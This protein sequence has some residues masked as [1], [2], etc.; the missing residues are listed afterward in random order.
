ML[1]CG[2]TF[3][4]GTVIVKRPQAEIDFSKTYRIKSRCEAL[5]SQNNYILSASGQ[6]F[7]LAPDSGMKFAIGDSLAFFGKIYPLKEHANTGAFSYERYLKQQGVNYKVFPTDTIYLTG[8]SYTPYSFFQD[9]RDKLLLKTDRLLKD[10]TNNAIIKALCTGYRNDMDSDIQ[11]LFIKTGT[12][13]LLSVSGLHTGAIYLLIVFLFR[14]A[15][16]SKPRI[17]LFII[18]LLWGYTCLTGL[19]PSVVRAATILTFI[20]IGNAFQKDYTPINSIAASAFLTL[21]LQPLVLYSVSFQMSYSAYCGIITLY[22]LLNRLPGKLPPVISSVWSLFC[23]SVTAQ[24]PTLPLT[25]YYFHTIGINNFLV[26]IIA[27]PLATLLL[28]AGTILLIL[29][30]AIGIHLVFI[31]NLINHLLLWILKTFNIISINLENLYPTVLHIL[32]L[33]LCLFS[34][35][36]FLIY[37]QQRM[38]RLSIISLATILLYCCLLNFTIRS[39]SEL[40]IFHLYN[41]SCILLNHKGY[42]TFLKNDADSSGLKTI[43]PYLFI[44]KVEPL[45]V[46][47]G[48]L[49]DQL[50]YT[51]NKLLFGPDTFYIADRNHKRYTSGTIIITDNLLPEHLFISEKTGCPV[52]III[53]GSNK[54]FYLKKWGEFCQKE[55]IPL[56]QTN[57]C[58]TISFPLK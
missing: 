19:S 35:S 54:R 36:L 31:I 53:D 14:I 28:Y 42:Y 15:G 4:C 17:H 29:P 7:Y 34:V 1:L 55:G 48:F 40:V 32:L 22:P 41:K 51:D 45:P 30:Y 5:L 44:N 18:P 20:I 24:L 50:L 52:R 2:I 8:H 23:I 57:E 43:R 47:T 10:S 11:N 13:H 46:N 3:L 56:L 27:V 25:A 38:L 12:V 9:I 37:R 16:I 39:K 21:L 49:S 33:Y 26:N 58:G 6:K